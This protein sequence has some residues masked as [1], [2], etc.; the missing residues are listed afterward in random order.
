MEQ[1]LYSTVLAA[2]YLNM[3]ISTL[4]Y[5]IHVAKN[6]KGV[7]LGHSLVFTQEILDEFYRN[8]RPQGRPPR[9]TPQPD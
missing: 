9:K 4:K 5:H 7:L 2:E 1:K 8:R 3:D 6:L